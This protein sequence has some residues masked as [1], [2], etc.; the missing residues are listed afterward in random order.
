MY[1]PKSKFLQ[2]TQMR[3]LLLLRI[4]FTKPV[5]SDGKY[6]P[7]IIRTLKETDGQFIICSSFVGFPSH[8]VI[9]WIRSG[10]LQEKSLYQGT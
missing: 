5:M 10:H 9:S 4:V 6:V 1:F 2:R 7:V 8:S 3:I